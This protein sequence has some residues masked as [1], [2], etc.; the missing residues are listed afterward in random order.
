[1]KTNYSLVT[2]TV[3]R[4]ND[5]YKYKL[6]G[7]GEKYLANHSDDQNAGDI[8]QAYL[9]PF[10]S[11]LPVIQ[12]VSLQK[13][14]DVIGCHESGDII[15]QA[16]VQCTYEDEVTSKIKKCTRKYYVF[17][18]SS[19]DACSGVYEQLNSECLDDFEI[20]SLTRTKVI[21]LI[22]SETKSED[23]GTN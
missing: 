14:E 12:T 5:Q 3:I 17:A 18:Q 10:S 19:L 21:G 23:D 15:F 4:R 20:V 13:V 6:V 7:K 16:N 11:E 2:A 9:K 8:C 22:D 1:M